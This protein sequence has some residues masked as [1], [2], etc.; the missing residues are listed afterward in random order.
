MA[1]TLTSEHV[2]IFLQGE[3]ASCLYAKANP[4]SSFGMNPF[5]TDRAEEDLDEIIH[6]F[7]HTRVGEEDHQQREHALKTRIE[8]IMKFCKRRKDEYENV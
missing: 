2:N 7:H 6:R 1:I 5:S 3:S 4:D 8:A